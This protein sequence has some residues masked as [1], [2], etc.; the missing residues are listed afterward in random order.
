MVQSNLFKKEIKMMWIIYFA[1]LA[2]NIAG[3]L[4]IFCVLTFFA[5]LIFGIIQY[6]DEKPALAKKVMTRTAIACIIMG[7][8]VAIIPSKQTIYMM[9][10]ADA[11]INL[12]HTPEADKV[13]V[14]VNAGLDKAIASLNESST[15]TAQ[16]N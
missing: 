8:F 7:I 2:G 10:G 1:A 13:R 3:L 6:V 16:N 11:A 14:L 15:E 4:L 9:I 12:S 5:G